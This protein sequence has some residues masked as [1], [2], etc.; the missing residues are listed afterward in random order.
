MLNG[1][2]KKA[3]LRREG[4]QKT[5]GVT[6]IKRGGE[7]LPR[8]VRSVCSSARVCPPRGKKERREKKNVPSIPLADRKKHHTNSHPRLGTNKVRRG[9]PATGTAGKG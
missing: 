6:S 5:K 7:P 8:G 4:K 3:C 1:K 2:G 9:L